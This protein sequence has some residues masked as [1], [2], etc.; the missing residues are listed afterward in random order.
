M[1]LLQRALGYRFIAVVAFLLFFGLAQITWAQDLEKA[2]AEAVTN[3]EMIACASDVLQHLQADMN[4][5][6]AALA[7]TLGPERL[8]ELEASQSAWET[9]VEAS[10]RFSASEVAGGSMAPLLGLVDRIKQTK[11][12]LIWLQGFH[13]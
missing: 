11:A 2:C 13:E 7:D 6:Y 10:A 9:Y 5:A 3:A 8:S 12:R 4:A 1:C